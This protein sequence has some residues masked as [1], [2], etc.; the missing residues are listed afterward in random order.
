MKLFTILLALTFTL[1]M[2]AQ[3]NKPTFEKEGD[4]TKATYFHDNGEIAQTG[5]FA[6]GKLHGQWIMFDED[7]K[8]IAKGKY[9][10]GKRTGKWLF[11][12]GEVLK[13]VDFADNR[14]ASVVE[15]TNAKPVVIN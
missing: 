15:S 8:K 2:N 7:G 11:W 5:Y 12:E 10:M 4:L 14:I 3:E 9:D 1:G 6:E 13:E